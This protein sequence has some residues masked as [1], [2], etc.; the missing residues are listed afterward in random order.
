VNWKFIDFDDN[1]NRYEIPPTVL[2]AES[3]REQIRRAEEGY[4]HQLAGALL[5]LTNWVP[6][7]VTTEI[8]R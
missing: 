8:S 7:I 4:R 1:A 2:S 3:A 6:P 5:D